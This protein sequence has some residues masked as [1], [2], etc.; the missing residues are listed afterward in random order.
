V[1]KVF[2]LL[3]IVATGIGLSGCSYCDWPI[4]LPHSC[5]SAPAEPAR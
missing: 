1:S 5:R 3:V 2:I 4:Y